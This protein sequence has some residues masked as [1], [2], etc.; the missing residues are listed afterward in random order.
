MTKG[1]RGGGGTGSARFLTLGPYQPTLPRDPKVPSLPNSRS[2]LRHADWERGNTCVLWGIWGETGDSS[3]GGGWTLPREPENHILRDG[4]LATLPKK[5]SGPARSSVSRFNGSAGP[6]SARCPH[7]FRGRLGPAAIQTEPNNKGP[8][9][10]GGG[11]PPG[12]GAGAPAAPHP[13]TVQTRGFSFSGLRSSGPALDLHAEA[14]R[15]CLHSGGGS[16]GARPGH[17]GRGRGVESSRD[18]G[19]PDCGVRARRVRRVA[20]PFG[21]LGFP[22]ANRL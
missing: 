11:P 16:A 8:A 9:A 5:A 15:G 4:R 14:A 10:D 17:G 20:S 3:N 7:A 12:A 21:D 6:A 13:A 19:A 22:R 2:E 18:P 1:V